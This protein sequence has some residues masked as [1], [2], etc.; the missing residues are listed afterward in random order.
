VL[1][2]VFIVVEAL[3]EMKKKIHSKSTAITRVFKQFSSASSKS[4]LDQPAS[5]ILDGE[6]RE[7][8]K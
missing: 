2:I 5:Q 6:V 4:G 1:T 7:N 3:Q 8:I